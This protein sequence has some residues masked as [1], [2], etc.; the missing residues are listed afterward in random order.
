MIYPW[1]TVVIEDHNGSLKVYGDPERWPKELIA[2][3][4]LAIQYNF[5]NRAEI[6]EIPAG[7]EKI[8][9]HGYT[10]KS[11]ENLKIVFPKD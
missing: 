2:R 9:S 1:Y 6:V 3:H 7:Q 4:R 10:F 11:W 5:A 8:W